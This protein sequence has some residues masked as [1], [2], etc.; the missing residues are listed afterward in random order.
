MVAM[1]VSA[2]ESRS[3]TTIELCCRY[4]HPAVMCCVPGACYMLL[5][6][7]CVVRCEADMCRFNN[8]SLKSFP[9]GISTTEVFFNRGISIGPDQRGRR[10]RGRG[11]V[12]GQRRE[13]RLQSAG[14]ALWLVLAVTWDHAMPGHAITCMRCCPN[15][16]CVSCTHYSGLACLRRHGRGRDRDQCYKGRLRL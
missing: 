11:Q 2:W 9:S 12:R 3:A 6:T 7:Y 13:V 16:E 15:T 1:V 5:V 8:S 10:R 14:T 4:R